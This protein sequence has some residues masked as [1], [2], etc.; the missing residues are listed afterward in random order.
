MY[1]PQAGN[2][3]YSRTRRAL[4]KTKAQPSYFFDRYQ[5]GVMNL[6]GYDLNVDLSFIRL[7][8]HLLQFT[9]LPVVLSFL[10]GYSLRKFFIAGVPLP[11]LRNFNLL[12]YACLILLA[13]HFGLV[14]TVATVHTFGIERYGESIFAIAMLLQLG[15]LFYL[16]G[17][18][19]WIWKGP[20]LSK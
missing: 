7:L 20:G 12:G 1:E 2:D 16:C 19:R 3:I 6:T 11:E 18:G 8:Y 10:V 15:C 17:A 9:F 4:L 13:I 14:L 5:T